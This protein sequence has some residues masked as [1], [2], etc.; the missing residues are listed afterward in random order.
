MHVLAWENSLFAL[1]GD[2]AVADKPF[3]NRR[4]FLRRTTVA[5]GAT[6]VTPTVVPSSVPGIDGNVAPSNRVSVGM[7]GKDRRGRYSFSEKAT[8]GRFLRKCRYWG[9]GRF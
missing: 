9:L 8:E 5:A 3:V 4:A 2:G 7:I 6:W 1:T